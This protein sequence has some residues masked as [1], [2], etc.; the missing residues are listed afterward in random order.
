MEEAGHREGR[1]LSPV[2]VD[3]HDRV[4]NRCSGGSR[5]VDELLSDCNADIPP[6]GVFAPLLEVSAFESVYDN[7]DVVIVES[8]G[9]V[10]GVSGDLIDVLQLPEGRRGRRVD[11]DVRLDGENLGDLDLAETLHKES[12]AKVETLQR[13]T[14]RVR[15]LCGGQRAQLE[16]VGCASRGE[17]LGVLLQVQLVQQRRQG[18]ETS[19]VCMA[20]RA[21]GAAVGRELEA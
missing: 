9:E 3:V 5:V 6:A 10:I 8:D 17:H 15:R 13:H 7:L 11:P 18:A 12:L 2:N 1:R 21:C 14:G 16:G 19:V 4:S 20:N